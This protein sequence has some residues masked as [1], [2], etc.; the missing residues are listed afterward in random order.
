M[1]ALPLYV[2]QASG[3][4]AGMREFFRLVSMLVSIPVALY[5]GWPF[6]EGAWRALKA[7]SVSMDVPV[8][9]GIVIAFVASVWNALT[10]QGEVYFDS[11]TMFVFFLAL[12]RYVE[13][14]ARHRAGSV[15]DALARLAPVTARRVRDG[16]AEDVQAVELQAGDEM[17][18]RTGEVFAADGR[19]RGRRRAGRRIDA[20]RRVDGHRQAG[21][22][23]RACRNPEPRCAVARAGRGRRRA[24]RCSPASSRCSSARR[25]SGRGSPRPPTVPRPGS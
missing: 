17:L 7:R 24:T 9:L 23:D 11:V 14:V 5:S 18:V 4:E 12:G 1:F 22:L 6:Y 20:H 25:R 19:D 2:A 8:T 13:M 21:R 10:G 3:M 15:A 16:E